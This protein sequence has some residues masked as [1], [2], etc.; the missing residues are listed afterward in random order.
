MAFLTVAG[1][2]VEVDS[3]GADEQEA[4]IGGEDVYSEAGNLR[5]MESWTK[6]KWNFATGWLSQA[7]YNTL[8]AAV[9]GG[10]IVACTGDAL[11][12]ATV[13]CRV[14]FGGGPFIDIA[15]ISFQ[16]QARLT[17]LES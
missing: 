12:G 15:G 14:R 4:E 6:R 3:A 11:D 2:T 16:R 17:L 8:K 5:V 10:A 13:Y 1:I 9:A 7:N